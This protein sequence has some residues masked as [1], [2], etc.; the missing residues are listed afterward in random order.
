MKQLIALSRQIK[1]I[2]CYVPFNNFKTYWKISAP[3]KFHF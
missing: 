1:K 3:N 2:V